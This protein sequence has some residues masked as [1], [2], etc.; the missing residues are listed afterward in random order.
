MFITISLLCLYSIIVLYAITPSLFSLQLA[1]IGAGYILFFVVRSIDSRV[2][3]RFWGIWYILCLLIL[4]LSLFGPEVR[5][6]HRWIVIEDQRIQP[7]EIVKPILITAIAACIAAFSKYTLK[8]FMIVTLMFIVPFILVFKQP[9]LGNA[10]VYA[11]FFAT[12][13]IVSR[14]GMRYILIPFFIISLTVPFMWHLLADYQK[15][16]ISTF[17]NP[18]YD[19]QG[20]GYNARQSLIAVGSGGLWGKGLGEG[21]QSKLQFLPE[22]HTDFIFASTIEQLGFIGGVLLI[23][24]YLILITQLIRGGSRQSEPYKRLV[25]YGVASQLFAQ[26]F[27]NIGMNIGIVPIT[28]I[29]L[30]LFSFG[31]SSIIATF[32][33]LGLISG[34]KQKEKQPIAIR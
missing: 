16:R 20:A 1:A 28:G 11:T 32:L 29:T 25:M 34:F 9:D 22:F 17:F 10:I 18:G 19:I 3:Q 33:G 30:P 12:I 7:S 5:G 15:Q 8:Q 13:V 14:F 26:I 31:G 6:S 2:F 23:I 27:I 24:F 4:V 21:T